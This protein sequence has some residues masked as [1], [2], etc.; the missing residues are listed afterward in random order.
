MPVIQSSFSTFWPFT[1]AHIS[2]IAPNKLRK[3]V[4]QF[5]RYRVSTP[6]DDCI[7]LDFSFA[8]NSGSTQLVIALHGLEG[9]SQSN[10]ILGLAKA[11]NRRGI[12][13]A[14]MNLRGCS[15]EINPTFSSYHSGKTEDLQA[16][17]QALS[18]FNRYTKIAIIG[19]SLGGNLTLKFAS[20]YQL[21]DSIKAICGVSVPVDL[22]GSC[23]ELSKFNNVLYLNRFLGQ[24]K[25][26]AVAKTKQFP[27]HNLNMEQVLQSKNFYEFDDRYT[28]P[29]NGFKSASDYYTTCSSLPDLH[30]LKVPTLLLN[31]QNDSF[32]SPSCY[33]YE[34]AEKS[35]FLML[36][37][38]KHGGHVGFI[39]TLP[40][41]KEQWFE[42]RL[43]AF[44]A[45]QF[46]AS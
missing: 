17:I 20:N 23:N 15:G 19:F 31:A 45:E 10:Y 12:H 38:P 2:T 21:P 36:E 1:N 22:A 43:C 29:L 46:N 14:A 5:Q 33:P 11:V 9:S 32:L 40:L 13:F 7:D 42:K 27:K 41:A 35:D 34:V 24:L 16:V 4:V 3:N 8:K 25:E 44:V 28:A 37:T 30:K 18:A 39:S 26:K 6:D